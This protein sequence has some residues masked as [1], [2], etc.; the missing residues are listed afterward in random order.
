M[1][2]SL[3]GVKPGAVIEWNKPACATIRENRH[4]PRVAE[5]PLFEG[6]A[7]EFDFAKLKDIDIVSG[8]PPCQP[9]SLG[10][11]HCGH[12][13]ARDMFPTAA[14]AAARLRPKAF[15]FEN[16]KGLA[17]PSFA[18]YFQ[19]ILLRL[20]FP[21]IV[22][23]D[24]ERWRDHLERLERKSAAGVR[25]G[26]S[27]K[28]VFKIVNAADYGV[29]QRR[30]RLFI[31]GF[32]GD[33]G[34]EWSFP[35][36]THSL[37]GLLYSQWISGEYWEKHGIKR[38][39][40]PALDPRRSAR[41]AKLRNVHPEFIKAPWLTVRD[42]LADLPPPYKGLL[43]MGERKFFNHE[44]QPGARLYNGHSGSPLDLPAKTIKAGAHGVPGGE[45]ML[46]DNA[47]NP[48][49]FTIREA[50]RLQCFPDDYVFPGSWSESMRQLGN[51]VPVKLGK[52]MLEAI[53]GKLN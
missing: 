38:E 18:K 15:I 35:S 23:K 40:R 9:F 13:D 5:W 45:N 21:E 8:G 3:A 43:D 33:L 11:K 37:D 14:D 41:V 19:Y 36:P 20:S 22:K 52:I 48:R 31:V 4:N 16:V 44:Y 27:Y 32:R 24:G 46:V 34:I 7:R 12:E 26:L 10:G 39:E 42:A 50:A 1:G 25:S 30:E 47:G 6:D 49:Y 17:R 28:V 53:V 51:A 2:A 29:P